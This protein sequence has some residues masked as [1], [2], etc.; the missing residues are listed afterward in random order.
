MRVLAREIVGV[1]AHVEG[2]EQ[3]GAG[4]FHA[5]D[6]H[7]I[8]RLRV[9][10]GTDLRAC[11]RGKPGDAVEVLHGIRDA[12]EGPELCACSARLIDGFRFGERTV[13]RDVREGADLAVARVDAFEGSHGDRLGGDVAA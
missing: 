7:G 1:F 6:E 11:A 3:H 13:A 12:G 5:G 4:S 2:A 8:V 9:I 10:A